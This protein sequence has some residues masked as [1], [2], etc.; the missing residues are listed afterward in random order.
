MVNVA[1]VMEANKKVVLSKNFK[2]TKNQPNKQGTVILTCCL[3]D[4]G[5]IRPVNERV[6]ISNVYEFNYPTGRRPYA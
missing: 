6:S 4:G 2:L 1:H 5:V 3:S